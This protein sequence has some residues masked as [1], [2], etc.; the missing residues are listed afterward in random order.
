MI[1]R[2]DDGTGY[3]KKSDLYFCYMDDKVESLREFLDHRELYWRESMSKEELVRILQ[4]NDLDY[5]EGIYKKPCA[6]WCCPETEL[7]DP[8]SHYGCEDC[9]PHYFYSRWEWLKYWVKY[10]FTSFWFWFGLGSGFMGGS[11]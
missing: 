9:H 4:D 6:D 1:R 7:N 10:P 11:D 3:N 8:N 2:N 5:I